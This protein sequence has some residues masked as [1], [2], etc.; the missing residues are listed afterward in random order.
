MMWHLIWCWKWAIGIQVTY[1]TI[2]RKSSLMLTNYSIFIKCTKKFVRRVS[3]IWRLLEFWCEWVALSARASS[4]HSVRQTVVIFQFGSYLLLYHIHKTQVLMYNT[5]F[6]FSFYEPKQLS[7][8]RVHI[9]SI[10][11]KYMAQC[12]TNA[13]WRTQSTGGQ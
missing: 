9:D 7:F 4:W 10:C 6:F 12:R 3:I 13:N 8:I 1:V 5:L 11:R 2:S